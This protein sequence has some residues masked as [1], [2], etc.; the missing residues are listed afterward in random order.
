VEPN[1]DA[2]T[3]AKSRL[4]EIQYNKKTHNFFWY[5]SLVPLTK[6]D[7][8]IISTLS[9]GRVSLIERLLDLGHSRFL[10]EKMVCQSVEEYTLLISKM[11]KFNGKGWVNT[12]PRCFDSYRKIKNYLGSPNTIHLSV[13]ANSDVGLGTNAIHYIDLF[14]WLAEDY[15]ISL[16]G[17]FLLNTLLP[18]KRGK[19]FKEFSGTLVGSLGN[20]SFLSMTFVP[21][22]TGGL[23]V[24]ISGNTGNFV[25][26][27]TN[28]KI[29]LLNSKASD[30]LTFKYEHVSSLSTRIIQDILE[31]DNCSLPDL[32]DSFYAHSELFR[33]FNSHIGKMLK[34]E[35]KL[36]PIT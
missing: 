5:E 8:V 31:M 23:I 26:D 12:T 2:Q 18:N 19:D 25:I 34:Q 3:L 35:M 13:L 16:N 11:K 7:V 24:N 17:E 10:I 32:S 28:E 4:N 36:C 14:C 33:V 27:E 22:Y 1:K 9:V 21:S 20:G 30:N 15:K 6:S 29:A